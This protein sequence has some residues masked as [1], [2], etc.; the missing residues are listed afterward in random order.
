MQTNLISPALLDILECPVC[1][2]PIQPAQEELLCIGCGRIYPILD[3]IPV[4]LAS[5]ARLLAS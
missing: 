5:S 3:G 1:H 2:H 4:M